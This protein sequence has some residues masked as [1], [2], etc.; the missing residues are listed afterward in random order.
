MCQPSQASRSRL[1]IARRR[2]QVGDLA[3]VEALIG[4]RGVL[5]PL[6]LAVGR[7]HRRQERRQLAGLLLVGG[8]GDRERHL[9][10]LQLTPRVG[11]DVDLVVL[12][13]LLRVARDRV[14][15][16][17]GRPGRDRLR[18]GRDEVLRDP[19]G[20]L[21]L[22]AEPQH[23]PADV[24]EEAI[25]I[26]GRRGGGGRRHRARANGKGARCEESRKKG[27]AG[28]RHTRDSSPNHIRPLR[29]ARMIAPDGPRDEGSLREGHR[30][31]Y[32]ARS[33]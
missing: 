3:D 8:R 33:T 18:V 14:C 26:R 5:A 7:V 28:F 30:R 2:Q 10:Q 23:R 22:D 24:R 20:A 32:F 16:E 17:L 29:S 1:R 19:R 25:D 12:H 21:L 4:L 11:R 13:G 31:E 15:V 6:A 9:Q 27:A